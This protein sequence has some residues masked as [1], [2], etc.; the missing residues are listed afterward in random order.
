[1]LVGSCKECNRKF[2][3]G[4]ERD[5][6]DPF[7]WADHCRIKDCTLSDKELG[8][9]TDKKLG[10]TVRLDPPPLPE[11]PMEYLSIRIRNSDGTDSKTVEESY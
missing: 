5:K 2:A 4:P 8:Y 9:K 10:L 1:M 11:K 6:I 3:F 7:L